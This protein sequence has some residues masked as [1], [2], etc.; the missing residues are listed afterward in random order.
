MKAAQLL[1]MEIRMCRVWT[2]E[3]MGPETWQG[4]NSDSKET[5]NEISEWEPWYFQALN[6]GALK[7]HLA[8]QVSP[9]PSGQDGR[10]E[11]EA[12]TGQRRASFQKTNFVLFETEVIPVCVCVCVYPYVSMLYGGASE[13][14]KK[15]FSGRKKTTSIW[16]NAGF[17]AWHSP[18]S[19]RQ[20]G[21]KVFG[22]EW[23]RPELVFYPRG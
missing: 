1:G 18:H 19:R 8:S 20:W 9:L 17:K 14:I 13:L 22:S 4:G 2:D 21:G 7:S 6:Q 23:A 3:R 16:F 11:Q 15:F 12:E 10:R 5:T